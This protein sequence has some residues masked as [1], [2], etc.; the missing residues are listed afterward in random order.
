MHR[1]VHRLPVAGIGRLRHAEAA[2]QPRGEGSGTLSI[3]GIAEPSRRAVTQTING[4]NP[5]QLQPLALLA[6]GPPG[7]AASSQNTTGQAGM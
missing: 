4:P 1:L 5:W 2:D 3:S 7:R 6:A